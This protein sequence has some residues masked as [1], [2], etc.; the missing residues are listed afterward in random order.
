MAFEGIAPLTEAEA[1][2]ALAA[3]PRPDP[4]GTATPES[5]A[6]TGPAFELRAGGGKGVFVVTKKGTR[7]WIEA[8]VG[9]AEIGRAHV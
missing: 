3:D 5:M 7:L 2:E 6:A 8:G 4:T 9:K 1:V